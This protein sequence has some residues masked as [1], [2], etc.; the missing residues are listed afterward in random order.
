MEFPNF[1]NQ[2]AV[3]RQTINNN[4]GSERDVYINSLNVMQPRKTTKRLA[5][6]QN[7]PHGLGEL[8]QNEE[9]AK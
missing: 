4:D 6:G 3:I 1:A 2:P 9:H 5:L 7:G 8:V